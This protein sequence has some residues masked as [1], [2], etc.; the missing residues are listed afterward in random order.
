VSF[1]AAKRLTQSLE[2]G[3]SDN[4]DDPGGATNQGI[5]QATWQGLGF[6]GSVLDA[7]QTLLDLAYYKYWAGLKI[8]D[9]AITANRPL[10]EVAPGPADAVAFQFYFNVPPTAFIKAFQGVV[11]AKM[12]GVLGPLT[13]KALQ[14]WNGRGAALSADLLSAQEWHYRGHAKPEFLPGLLNRVE[15]VREWLKNA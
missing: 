6:T 8:Y 15:K 1:A 12:D 4:P 10:F 9:P 7:T 3:K 11:G 2:G 5:T 14:G 13:L